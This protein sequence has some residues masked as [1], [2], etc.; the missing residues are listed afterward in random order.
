M[1]K[2]FPNEFTLSH[3]YELNDVKKFSSFETAD[4]D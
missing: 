3:V 2:N 4:R 1:K